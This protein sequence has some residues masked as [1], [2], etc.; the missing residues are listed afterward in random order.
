MNKVTSH[1]QSIA[2]IVSSER[3]VFRLAFKNVN[4]G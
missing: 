3:R 2:K 4:G 1:P